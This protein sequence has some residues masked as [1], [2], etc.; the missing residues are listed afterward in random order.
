MKE[1]LEP[2]IDAMEL[3]TVEV[4][5]ESHIVMQQLLSCTLSTYLLR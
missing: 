2:I 4:I 3:C 5:A 1:V